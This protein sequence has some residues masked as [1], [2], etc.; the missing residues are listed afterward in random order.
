MTRSLLYHK[1]TNST[2]LMEEKGSTKSCIEVYR[3]WQPL[4]CEC[5]NECEGV[6]N[7]EEVDK[8]PV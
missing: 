4:R 3:G 6:F 7:P 8:C 2:Y 5:C 1:A